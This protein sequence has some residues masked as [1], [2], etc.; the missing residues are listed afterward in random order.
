MSTSILYHGW[1]M[2]GYDYL[3]TKYER[4]AMIFSVE[5][6]DKT[7]CCPECGRTDVVC[8]GAECVNLFETV[9]ERN[10]LL[11]SLS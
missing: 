9:F 7:V 11:T 1:G 3:S 10:L 8:R 4:G 6:R 5:P 2:V